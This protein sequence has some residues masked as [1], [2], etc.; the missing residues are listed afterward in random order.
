MSAATITQ[1]ILAKFVASGNTDFA[2][3]SGL[4]LQ[5]I[6]ENLP[7]PVI[8]FV[9]G[10]ER[11][12]YT[13]ERDYFDLGSFSFTI[14]AE[15]LAETE[16]LALNVLA[17]FDVLVKAPQTLT[18]T[19]GRLVEWDKTNYTISGEP[20]RDENAKQVGRADFTYA[21]KAQKLL[22]VSS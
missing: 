3:S 2:A 17:I 15:G 9:H 19:G 18:W 11:S 7:L 1:A 14:F 4:W 13:S 6:P 16:R 20:I 21:Y 22:P 8:G 12:E 5:E 10:G